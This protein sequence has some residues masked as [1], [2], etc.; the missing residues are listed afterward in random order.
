FYEGTQPD[1]YCDLHLFSSEAAE[2]GIQ[3]LTRQG[4]FMGGIDTRLRLDLS[5]LDLLLAPPEPAPPALPEPTPP[6]PP[7]PAD[8]LPEEAPARPPPPPEEPTAPPVLD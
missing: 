5:D 2:R 3:S 8:T 6:A 4:S 1:R 7:A